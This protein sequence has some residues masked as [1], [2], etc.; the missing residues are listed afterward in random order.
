MHCHLSHQQIIKTNHL[1]HKKEVHL[2]KDFKFSIKPK[3]VPNG[4][5]VSVN[6]VQNV[7]LLMANMNYVPNRQFQIITKLNFAKNS[8]A[9]SCHAPMAKDVCFCTQNLKQKKKSKSKLQSPKPNQA[10]KAVVKVLN[11]LFSISGDK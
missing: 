8:T 7:H 11:R 10:K 2:L 6:L 1:V 9:H 5:K 3:Y 4:S